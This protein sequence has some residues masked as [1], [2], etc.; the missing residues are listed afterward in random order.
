MTLEP[1]RGTTPETDYLGRYTECSK[2]KRFQSHVHALDDEV[3]EVCSS[4]PVVSGTSDGSGQT[5]TQPSAIEGG[6]AT[7]ELELR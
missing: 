6:K 4:A 2:A 7:V 5:N 1:E 3:R